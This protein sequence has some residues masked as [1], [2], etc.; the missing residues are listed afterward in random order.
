[1]K[2]KEN[3]DEKERLEK[4]QN[5]EHFLGNQE[6]EKSTATKTITDNKENKKDSSKAIIENKLIN[7][8]IFYVINKNDEP[9]VIF[10]EI[11]LGDNSHLSYEQL[12]NQYEDIIKNK[13]RDILSK[14]LRKYPH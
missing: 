12:K 3:L 10:D 9:C 2:K 6:E 4:N 5:N 14:N 1:M 13:K 8:V 7:Q 11:S